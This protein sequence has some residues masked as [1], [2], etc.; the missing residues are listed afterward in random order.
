MAVNPP[1]SACSPEGGLK[2][3]APGSIFMVGLRGRAV[4]AGY[5]T[6]S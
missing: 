2:P 5:P 4:D 6:L 1:K 3:V